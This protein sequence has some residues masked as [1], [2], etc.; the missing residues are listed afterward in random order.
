MTQTTQPWESLALTS[1]WR[2][3]WQPP[4]A[5]LPALPVLAARGRRAGPVVLITGGVHGDEYEGPAAIYSLFNQLDLTT[6]AGQ[7]IGLPVVNVAAWQAHARTSPGDGVDLNRVFPGTG[8]RNAEPSR[9]LAGEIFERFVRPCDAL[10]DLHSGGA[11][12]VHL[13]MVGW[14]AGGGEAERLARRFGDGLMPWLIPHVAGVLSCEAHRAG[15][16]AIGAEYG[17][18]ARLDPGGV[19]AYVAG[20]RRVLALLAGDEPELA[21]PDT[22]RPIAGSYQTVE[23]G[24]LFVA[25]VN[26]GDHVTPAT[27]L[28]QLY[29]LLGEAV[30]EVKAARAGIV[31]ALAHRALLGPGDRVAYVG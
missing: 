3:W 18:G 9:Q 14:Y 16:V 24:G 15:K 19:A 30:D 17:G 2:G 12:L 13:P 25:R 29:S 1:T 22:R 31:A 5:G 20:L 4:V 28:G 10:I 26:L 27:V 23:Q 21:P 8:D 6:L 11:R 7:V